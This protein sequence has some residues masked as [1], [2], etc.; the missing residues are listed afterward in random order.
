MENPSSGRKYWRQYLAYGGVAALCYIIPCFLFIKSDAFSGGWTLYI[1]NALF[2]VTIL[3][4][5]LKLSRRKP[6]EERGQD[7][8][9]A[10]LLASLVGT[11]V[12][13][14]LIVLLL[15]F[16]APHVF[17]AAPSTAIGQTSPPQILANDT[18]LLFMLFSN[19]ILA[20]FLMGAFVS[21]IISFGTRQIDSGRYAKKREHKK[22]AG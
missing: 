4:Y 17:T 19:A 12:S 10:G 22:M 15:V 13:C 3:I 7:A 16:F 6:N 5:S 21:L 8:F 11:V 2:M 1:G 18:E 14:L 9:V 20:N